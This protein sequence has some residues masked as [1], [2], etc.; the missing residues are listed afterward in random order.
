MIHQPFKLDKT[1]YYLQTNTEKLV[2]LQQSIH[3]SLY[4]HL[5]YP[6]TPSYILKDR[7][8]SSFIYISHPKEIS[9]KSLLPF[10]LYNT[11]TG[12]FQ[13]VTQM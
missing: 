10:V 4:N 1:V 2:F 7:T 11:F 6:T 9:H 3:N 8:S 12:H 13:L 5:L